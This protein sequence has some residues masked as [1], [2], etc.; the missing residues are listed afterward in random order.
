M[1]RGI[2]SARA[3]YRRD[4]TQLTSPGAVRNALLRA[5]LASIYRFAVHAQGFRCQP[6]GIHRCK[7][8][9][10]VERVSPMASAADPLQSIPW[11][12]IVHSRFARA[13]Y[14]QSPHSS[15]EARRTSLQQQ[16]FRLSCLPK[17]PRALPELLRLRSSV[18]VWLFVVG[19]EKEE[20][21]PREFWP[22]R[23]KSYLEVRH[24][25]AHFR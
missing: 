2:K 4:S 7:H 1:R 10:R 20:F 16:S 18:L 5:M 6:P 14:T 19:F 12:R 21:P 3:S 8:P 17:E 23:S 24:R 13:N 15:S 25:E 22:E 11:Q 9:L